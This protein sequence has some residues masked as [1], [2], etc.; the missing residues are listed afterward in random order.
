MREADSMLCDLL[1]SRKNLLVYKH[2]IEQQLSE[3]QK[4]ISIAL[5]Q[6][7]NEGER[8]LTEHDAVWHGYLLKI[9]IDI[10]NNIDMIDRSIALYG[11]VEESNLFKDE[12][13]LLE[14]SM[15]MMR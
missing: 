1:K 3:S 9:F 2:E 11:N 14:E 12:D 8:Q 10:K 6:T 15:A 4:I 5:N 7:L 13:S